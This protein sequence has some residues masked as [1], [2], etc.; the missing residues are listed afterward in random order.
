MV[1]DGKVEDYHPPGDQQLEVGGLWEV[2]L[3]ACDLAWK[4][5]VG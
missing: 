1:G 3:N 4:N 5:E 2:E